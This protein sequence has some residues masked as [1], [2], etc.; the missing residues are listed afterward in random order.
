MEEIEIVRFY[1]ASFYCQHNFRGFWEEKHFY[2]IISV[3]HNLNIFYLSI[4][5]PSFFFFFKPLPLEFFIPIFWTV[6]LCYVSKQLLLSGTI[7]FDSGWNKIFLAHFMRY[8]RAAR[9]PY[10]FL[11][12][13]YLSFL[14][15]HD[16]LRK[17]DQKNERKRCTFWESFWIESQYV[18][19][20]QKEGPFLC[21]IFLSLPKTSFS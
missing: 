2:F 14:K 19:I 3:S 12:C 18:E 17:K 20:V 10:I 6:L 21:K 1:L 7:W 15:V 16:V 11:I 4:F 5:L 8:W 9:L 13:S